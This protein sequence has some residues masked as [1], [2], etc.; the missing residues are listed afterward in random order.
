MGDSPVARSGGQEDRKKRERTVSMVD[1]IG[2][3]GEKKRRKLD[4]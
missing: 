4:Q 2:V 1:E 3:R